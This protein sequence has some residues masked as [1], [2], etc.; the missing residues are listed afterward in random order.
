MKFV[1]G[2]RFSRLALLIQC[3]EWFNWS[4]RPDVLAKFLPL[5]FWFFSLPGKFRFLFF[6]LISR[7]NLI[8]SLESF[9]SISFASTTFFSC[10]SCLPVFAELF[11]DSCARYLPVQSILVLG[12]QFWV[13]LRSFGL[14][15][16]LLYR[17]LFIGYRFDSFFP[18]Y[19]CVCAGVLLGFPLVC[20]VFQ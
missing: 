3:Y 20:I 1:R 13:L 6:Q 5:P 7:M 17:V 18:C 9:V 12:C 11:P 2:I 19:W 4:R 15:T 10:S 16:D 14:P 8:V